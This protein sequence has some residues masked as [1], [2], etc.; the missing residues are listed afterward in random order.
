L[1]KKKA[2]R[3]A[4][5]VSKQQ[6]SRWEQQ[7]RRQR[8]V[9]AS[10]IALIVIVL[11]LVVAGWLVSQFLP[12]NETVIK[13]NDTEFKMRYYVEM[14]KFAG[15]NKPVREYL[16][17]LAGN[18]VRTIEETE[19]VRQGASKLKIS[20]SDDAVTKEL[21]KS[22]MPR[23]EAHRDITR[24]RLLVR[25]LMDEYFDK[26]VPVTADQ[27]HIMAILLESES[28]AKDIRAKLGQGASFTELAGKFSLD[29]RAKTNKGDFGWHPQN[30]FIDLYN[31]QMPADYAFSTEVGALSQPL[32][33]ARV[34]KNV[35]Y[36]LLRVL[37]RDKEEKTAHV[38]AILLSS[39][40]EAS[41]IRAKLLAGGDF[42]TLAEQYSQLEGVRENKGDLGI[43]VPGNKSKAFDDFVF[44]YDVELKT[45]SQP[46]RDDTVT[47]NGGYWLV[48]V[49][50]K[51]E[52]RKI[53]SEDRDWLKEKVFAEWVAS[54]WAD[55]TNNIDHSNLN[56]EKIAW[57]IS[58]AIK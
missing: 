2:Q 37:E 13:V 41:R 15:G 38:Q 11:A 21:K 56:E 46:I 50:G 33:D 1:A 24:T 30:I 31:I 32:Y 48:E 40:E 39:E 49:V 29:N 51:E 58:Q 19:L 44:N 43:V 20:V 7:K 53:A 54:L 52:N 26:Q 28:P 10:G 47:T 36:W 27:R 25:K 16:Q 18:V 57:A 3:P 8:L 9:S 12:M 42:A 35:G 5:Y 17:F 4:R 6:L 14:L 34:T 45:L 22:G 55:L 23:N